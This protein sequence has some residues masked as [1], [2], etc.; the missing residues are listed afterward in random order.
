VT[1]APPVKK[2]ADPGGARRGDESERSFQWFTPEKRR[3]TLYEDVTIDS[4][5][6]VHRHALRGWLVNFED[7]RTTWD[8][9]STKLASA[10]WY[11]FRDP[12]QR[13]ERPYY[14]IGSRD[15]QQ[16]EGAVREAAADRLFDD[17][18][19]AWVEFLRDNLQTPAF[20]ENGLWLVMATAARDCLSD[21]VSM[22]VALDAAMKQRQAQAIVLYALDLE[23]HFGEFPVERAKERFLTHAAWQ[24]TRRYLERMQTI[25]DWGEAIIATNVCFEPLVGTLIRRELGIR[26]A[27]ANG[28]AV[29]PNV[30]TVA[31]LEWHWAR[32]WTVAFTRFLLADDKHAGANKE[33]V[34]GWIA[35]WLPLAR[36]SAAAIELLTDELPHGIPF[37][38]CLQ[39]VGR[40][41]DEFFGEANVAAFT[42]VTA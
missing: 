2:F 34:A 41:A 16:I 20:M 14:Q 17:F 35:D 30:A 31:Q 8:D 19:P 12:G 10:D 42:E 27:I 7:G 21:S 13:W 25:T 1:S 6:S 29:T 3:A 33:V 36:E 9:R 39:R 40:D 4:Q 5:P 22:C 23:S 37:K 15:E 24:P 18:D 38:E 11:A 28:D 26:A 32:A